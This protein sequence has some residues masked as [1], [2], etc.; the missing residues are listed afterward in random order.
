MR[1]ALRRAREMGLDLILIEP[2]A[3][4]PVAK[5]MDDG[6]W[7]YEN[8]KKQHEAKKKVTIYHSPH[9]SAADRLRRV[10]PNRRSEATSWYVGLRKIATLTGN[11][12]TTHLPSL[13]GS[14]RIISDISRKLGPYPKCPSAARRRDGARWG[15]FDKGV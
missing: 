6:Q 8:K 1:A 5:A 11:A 13:F 9:R 14:G 2:T 4:P 15:T 7:E 12:Q 3:E 10:F